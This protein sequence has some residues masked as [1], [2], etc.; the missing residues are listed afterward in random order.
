MKPIQLELFEPQECESHV[1]TCKN[2]AY[3]EWHRF[4]VEREKKG[5]ELLYR[6][7]YCD[8]CSNYSKWCETMAEE[9]PKVNTLKS[10]DIMLDSMFDIKAEEL[11]NQLAKNEKLEKEIKAARLK[12]RDSLKYYPNPVNDNEKLFNY[13]RAWFFGDESAWGDLIRTAYLVCLKLISKYLR[14]GK[15]K[16]VF[17]DD[18]QKN[19]KAMEAM[20]YVLRR[21]NSNVGWCVTTNFITVLQDGVRHATEYTTKILDAVVYVEDVNLVK[22]QDQKKN[23]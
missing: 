21:Y 20:V 12:I 22:L 1:F 9:K 3:G 18:I 19:E 14:E 16:G 17:L 5:I 7:N 13:Q 4:T 15:N 10:V 11:K 2:C 6:C 23:I 8:D